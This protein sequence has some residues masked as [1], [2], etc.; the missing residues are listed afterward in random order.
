MS[1]LKD[2]RPI[3]LAACAAAA[4]LPLMAQGTNSPN[5][6]QGI[7]LLDDADSGSLCGLINS[8][9]HEFVIRTCDRQLIFVTGANQPTGFFADGNFNVTRGAGGTPAGQIRY[10]SDAGGFRTAF[11]LTDDGV[12]Q[13]YDPNS[14]TVQPGTNNGN[15]VLPGQVQTGGEFC[16][17]GNRLDGTASCPQP[18]A[19]CGAG[20]ISSMILLSGMFTM[21]LLRRS[22]CG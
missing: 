5:G 20:G 22:H 10:A 7:I 9:R 14:G 3:L 4:P 6:N 21:G 17:P 13:D 1:I 12:V 19:P 18:R 16:D 15:P 8:L 2:V 11:W